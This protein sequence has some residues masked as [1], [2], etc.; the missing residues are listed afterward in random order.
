M[1]G[2]LEAGQREGRPGWGDAPGRL[3][4]LEQPAGRQGLL[5]LDRV[6]EVL[7]DQDARTRGAGVLDVVMLAAAELRGPS[8]D[9]VEPMVLVTAFIVLCSG[10]ASQKLSMLFWALDAGGSGGVSEVELG[11]GIEPATATVVAIARVQAWADAPAPGAPLHRLVAQADTVT[12]K[13]LSQ[14]LPGDALFTK[15]DVSRILFYGAHHALASVTDEGRAAAGSEG[16]GLSG[17]HPSW[18]A[19]D[20]WGNISPSLSGRGSEGTEHGQRAQAVRR[21]SLMADESTRGLD[22]MT[23]P[24]ERQSGGAGSLT[25]SLPGDAG[26]TSSPSVSEGRPVSGRASMKGNDPPGAAYNREVAEIAAERAAASAMAAVDG[27][28]EEEAEAMR[29]FGALMQDLGVRTICLH[30]ARIVVALGVL[31]ANASLYFFLVRRAELTV[32][33]SF[34]W[35]VLFNVL[36]G[37]AALVLT[38]RA[39]NKD[40][41]DL[42]FRQLGALA[43]PDKIDDVAPVVEG[44]APEMTGVLGN[45]KGWMRRFRDKMGGGKNKADA[46]KRLA[47]GSR[48]L[49]ATGQAGGI[50]GMTPAPITP[51]PETHRR[52]RSKTMVLGT[53][54]TAMRPDQTPTGTASAA[55]NLSGGR[56]PFEQ[57]L[58]DNV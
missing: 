29:A 51:Q 37:A 27:G 36:F 46:A 23:S 5:R 17:T 53:L 3:L 45:V 22:A 44:L 26:G 9:E 40:N 56:T 49:G 58:A 6:A 8:A 11:S 21:L 35:L 19:G 20:T 34:A 30:I 57:R 10:K 14:H 50:V 48:D 25:G 52:N 54:D 33:V 2:L 13:V 7:R 38:T 18:E 24:K 4:A 16:G 12:R 39:M 41:Q 31:G 28:E 47:A 42:L 43:D 1:L 15:R 32:E 55:A